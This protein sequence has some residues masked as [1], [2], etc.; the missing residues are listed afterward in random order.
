[1]ILEMKRPQKVI[2]RILQGIQEE[3]DK[4]IALQRKEVARQICV[5]STLLL[6]GI[7][8]DFVTTG[9]S[10]ESIRPIIS[11]AMMDVVSVKG[12]YIHMNIPEEVRQAIEGFDA[13]NALEDDPEECQDCAECGGDCRFA[14]G[15]L[16][17]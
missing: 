11:R 9:R 2:R 7:T 5:A 4:M 15:K 13:D 12:K 8:R 17:I 1:M 14:G 6:E 16:P 10:A 3:R